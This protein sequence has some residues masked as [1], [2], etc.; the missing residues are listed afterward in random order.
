MI[1]RVCAEFYR[2]NP[3][4]AGGI[5]DESSNFPRI[6]MVLDGLLNNTPSTSEIDDLC[7]QL[8]RRYFCNYYWPVCDV[9]TGSIYPVCTSSCNLL[10]NNEV[11]TDYLMRAIDMVMVEGIDVVPSPSSCTRTLLLPEFLPDTPEPLLADTC[12]SIEGQFYTFTL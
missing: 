7:V 1:P 11:C 6:R 12:I 10:F 2:D 5:I 3:P 4:P 9:A 8:V